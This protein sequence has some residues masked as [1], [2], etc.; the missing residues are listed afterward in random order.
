MKFP[1]AQQG[2]EAH[3][4]GQDDALA[5]RDRDS[6]PWSPLA[7]DGVERCLA[8]SYQRGYAYGLQVALQGRYGDPPTA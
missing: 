2:H 7:A 1:T 8:A 4:R 3:V 5:G 6:G